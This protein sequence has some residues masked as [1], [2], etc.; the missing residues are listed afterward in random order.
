MYWAE[1]KSD[2]GSDGIRDHAA[3]GMSWAVGTAGRRNTHPA[4]SLQRCSLVHQK[5]GWSQKSI[6]IIKHCRIRLTQHP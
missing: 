4:M 1:H 5:L 3:S 6:F 2:G